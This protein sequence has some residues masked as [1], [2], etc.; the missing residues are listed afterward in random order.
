[1][2]NIRR[3]IQDFRLY[4]P[5]K[6]ML[7]NLKRETI[8][9]MEVTVVQIKFLLLFLHNVG[10]LQRGRRLETLNEIVQSVEFERR[11]QKNRLWRH[12]QI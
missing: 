7:Q 10:L 1:M 12:Y 5:E 9:K 4:C 6:V 2:Q 11:N 3:M 8:M